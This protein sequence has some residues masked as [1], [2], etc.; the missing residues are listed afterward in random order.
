VG[1][2]F[3]AA[4]AFQADGLRRHREMKLFVV[5]AKIHEV[6]FLAHLL[7][8]IVGDGSGQG[9]PSVENPNAMFRGT[10][11]SSGALHFKGVSGFHMQFFAH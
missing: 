4:A 5:R 10:Q 7:Q 8:R 9:L 3:V 11:T 6:A 2:P 1:Q